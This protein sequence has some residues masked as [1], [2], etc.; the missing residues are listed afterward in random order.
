MMRIRASE[1]E[2]FF[3]KEYDTIARASRN[4]LV[5]VAPILGDLS[6]LAEFKSGDKPWHW[7]ARIAF[8]NKYG[9]SAFL[10]TEIKTA[11]GL[12]INSLNKRYD[13]NYLHTLRERATEQELNQMMDGMGR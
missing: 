2:E 12:M 7:R 11:P 6:L 3:N 1:L 13:L 5:H 8:M 10:A 9:I 4:I